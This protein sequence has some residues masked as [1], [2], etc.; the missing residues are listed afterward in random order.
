MKVMLLL[1]LCAVQGT[2]AVDNK[3]A[4]DVQELR[5]NE[6]TQSIQTMSGALMGIAEYIVN[7]DEAVKQVRSGV[8]QVQLTLNDQEHISRPKRGGNPK[9]IFVSAAELSSSRSENER[10]IK[11]EILARKV[12]KLLAVQNNS[13]V[14]EAKEEMTRQIET[15]FLRML[16]A[17]LVTGPARTQM[18]T[19]EIFVL[20]R[21]VL[22]GQLDFRPVIQKLPFILRESE[23]NQFITLLKSLRETEVV[24]ENVVDGTKS[25]QFGGLENMDKI[26]DALG[27][28]DIKQVSGFLKELPELFEGIE[29]VVDSVDTAF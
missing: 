17:I 20:M 24:T 21:S 18:R 22:N 11:N 15:N 12:E 14:E 4:R 3:F 29:T 16:A 7:I 28:F 10:A 8:G 6:M 13:V 25:R 9:P 1:V 23:T 27:G 2:L 19:E 26:I 5:L